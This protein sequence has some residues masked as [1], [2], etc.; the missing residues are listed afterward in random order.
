MNSDR[1][2]KQ[3]N[4]ILEIDNIKSIFR[5][6]YIKDGS[7]K[8][9]DAE[10]S[11]HLAMMVM[12]LSEYFD[13]LDVSKTLKMVLA[14]DL[15]ELYAGD[16]YAYDEKGNIGKFDREKES[17]EKLFSLLPED[18]KKEFI[19]LWLEFEEANTKEAVCGS[20]VDR[21]QPLLLNYSSQGKSWKE[22]EISKDKVLKRNK[23]VFEEGPEEIGEYIK[24]IIEDA[25]HKGYL[26]NL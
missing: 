1:F 17:A 13:E 5:N 26:K 9:N 10:H 15:V 11:W 16:V 22:H 4:F 2:L 18:Q 3:I 19:D 20:I 23:I 8:E 21:F 6:N 7:R 14:H 25:A 24:S 12:V